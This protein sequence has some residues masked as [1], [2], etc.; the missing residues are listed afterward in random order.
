[1]KEDLNALIDQALLEI[2]NMEAP[3][4]EEAQT[5]EYTDADYAKLLSDITIEDEELANAEIQF[6]SEIDLDDDDGSVYASDLLTDNNKFFNKATWKNKNGQFVRETSDEVLFSV[7]PNGQISNKPSSDALENYLT[8]VEK[9]VEINRRLASGK[10]IRKEN[11]RVQEIK[12]NRLAFDQKIIPLA[13]EMTRYDKKVVVE[14]LTKNIRQLIKR[15]EKYINTRIAKLLS[16]AIPAGVKAAKLKWPWIFV[17]N[18]G[19]LYK[20]HPNMGEEL[21]FWATPNVPYY[22]RQGTE[23]TIL[24]ER[25]A[26]L[27]PYFL[28]CIDRA[29]HRYYEAK[30]RLANREILYASRIVN[31]NLRTYNDL[32][33]YNAFWWKKLYDRLKEERPY[34]KAS[35]SET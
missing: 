15:Y 29:I 14:E 18:P 11:K 30:R 12:I 7:S 25:D 33:K 19:F 4:K 24:E 31:N 16:P 32:L 5:M 26:Q 10:A 23:Q 35:R 20:T 1:M 28:E 22:F 2:S 9:A 8:P 3:S 6:A 21:T 34:E 27:S 17:A 13:D